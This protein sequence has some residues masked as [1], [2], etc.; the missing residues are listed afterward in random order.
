MPKIITLTTDFSLQDSYVGEMKG[1]IYSIDSEVNIVDISHLVEPQNILEGALLLSNF[2]HLY[3]K[4]TIH[5]AVIDP[6]VGSDR[7]GILME[8]ENHLFVGPDNGLFTMVLKNESV[9]RVVEL[10]NKDYFRKEISTTFHGRDIFAPVAAH[11]ANGV[12]PESFGKV[13]N[14]PKTLS[15]PSPFSSDSEIV[16]EILF[17][18]AFG[19]A[20]TNIR[21]KDLNG[22]DL[23]KARVKIGNTKLKGIKRTYSDV[24]EGEA[25]LLI[26]SSGCLE[27]AMNKD[28]AADE[29]E[30]ETRDKIKVFFS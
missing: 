29:L 21:K 20:T 4:G 27:I 23:S 24:E 22:R 17:I 19:N 8:T 30:L 18:D 11:A 2:Y 13:I 10:T 1:V 3:P 12:A 26:G 6:G 15:I 14:D 28:D 5:I 9:K 16:G 25:L 7:R